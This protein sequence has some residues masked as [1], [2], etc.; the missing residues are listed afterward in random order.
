MA[1]P[2]RLARL[3][4]EGRY[5]PSNVGKKARESARRLQENPPD[6]PEKRISFSSVKSRMITKKH[7]VNRETLGYSAQGSREM[8]N[9]SDAFDEMLEA[10]DFDNDQMDEYASLAAKAWHQLD[11]TGSAGDLAIYLAYDFLWYH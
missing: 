9:D 4:R 10:L 6:A 7:Y 5:Q 3:L 2:R 1:L 8:V 11:K